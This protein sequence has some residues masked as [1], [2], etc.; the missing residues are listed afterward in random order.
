MT[1]GGASLF[2]AGSTRMSKD[3]HSTMHNLA[4]S[5][6][7]MDTKQADAFLRRLEK[8]KRYCV[9]AYG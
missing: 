8:Q 9:E 4:M 2:V 7:A 1:K 5:R 6:G 3:V